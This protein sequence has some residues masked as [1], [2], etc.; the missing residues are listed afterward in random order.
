[1]AAEDIRILIVEDDLLFAERLKIDLEEM[2]YIVIDVVDN[3]KAAL[4]LVKIARPELVL[5]DINIR[6]E[7]DGISVA[8]QI[9]V[10]DPT[11]VIFIT[12]LS[13]QD[14]FNRAKETHPFA[15]L[16][17]PANKIS[18]EHSIELAIQNFNE[19]AIQKKLTFEQF[20]FLKQNL[21]I[22]EGNRLIKIAMAIID[23]IEVEEKYCS[24]YVEEKKYVVRI[25]LK[26]LMDKLPDEQFTRIHRNFVVNMDKIIAL[27]L[28]NNIVQTTFK[29]LPLGRKYRSDL[30]KSKGYIS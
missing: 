9:I 4:H 27:D 17:K 21:L 28:E 26:D 2:G 20:P 24:I 10:L 11:P 19:K 23:V 16:L 8:Q 30:I 14:T 29:N 22:K 6:G 13:D 15:Y 1:V 12:S 5:M 3:A 25:S 7:M 18:L